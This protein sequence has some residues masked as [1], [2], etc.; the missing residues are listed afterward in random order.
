MSGIKTDIDPRRWKRLCVGV[1]PWGKPGDLIVV[2][3]PSKAYTAFHEIH[4][5]VEK[6]VALAR[7]TGRKV[8]VR[9][10]DAKHSLYQDIRNAHCLI[11]HGSVAA[12]EAVI[13]G[14]PVFV[15]KTSA[16]ASVGK[17]DFDLENP[18]RPDRMQW[19]HSLA[20]SQYTLREI[21]AG[22]CWR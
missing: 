12:V 17:T 20:N 6:T 15:D 16:A 7:E 14:C 8:I 22:D 18:V 11:T 4:D 19:L 13:M 9:Q 3:A 1:H 21:L 2:A 5:W 10:K